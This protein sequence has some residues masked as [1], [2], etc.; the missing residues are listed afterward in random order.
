LRILQIARQFYPSIG[1]VEKFVQDLSRH[2]IRR[3]HQVAVVTLKRCFYMD[4]VLPSEA[5]V[6]GIK[7]YRIPY[8]GQRRFFLAPSVLKFVRDF[9][10]LH[11]HN[12]DF[13]L[14]YLAL[15][16]MWHSKP[17]VLSTH[18]GFFHT[19]ALGA[20][21]RLYFNTITRLTVK[22]ADIVIADSDHDRKLFSRIT[23]RVV[24]I[25][26][27]VD[28][29]GFSSIVKNI[30]P[31]SLVYIGRLASN[32][33]VD[34]LI[35]TLPFVREAYPA[36]HLTIIGVDSEGI[37][38]QLEQL[39]DSLGVADRITF[40]GEVGLETLRTYLAQAH[41]FVSASEYEAFGISVIEAMSSGTVPVVNDISPL[42][43]LVRNG[44]TGFVADF[45]KPA[46]A[47]QVISSALSCQNLQTMS[48][49]AKEDARKYAWE[50]VVLQFEQVYT[51]VLGRR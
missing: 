34:N 33:R 28:F 47:A 45:S 29:A 36:V 23:D 51:D 50:N 3:S 2:L 41:L 7:V 37:K 11:I 21:K 31:G 39:A 12:V 40:T 32:K 44:E 30:K 8:W 46:A 14:D 22:E 48:I 13:F 15:T 19:K 20:I 25:D 18:G 6:E 49:R 9:D 16:K 10:L 24:L 17:I 43:E 35:R 26:N 42:R 4:V 27:G 1:G 5:V 38:P